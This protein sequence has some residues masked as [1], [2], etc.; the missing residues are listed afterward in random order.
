MEELK[1]L[2][3][4]LSGTIADTVVD[5]RLLKSQQDREKY[6]R[7]VGELSAYNDVL[8]MLIWRINELESESV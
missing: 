6:L 4:A 7:K 8:N 3:Q 1:M 2:V 5:M